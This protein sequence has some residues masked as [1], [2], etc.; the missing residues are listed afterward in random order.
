MAK[1]IVR[2]FES[3][4]E[5]RPFASKGHAEI[6]H[7]GQGAVGRGVFEPG[8]KW[9]ESVK[10]LAGTR[11]CETP[12]LGF[13]AS[14]RMHVRMDDGEE[15]DIGP[16]DVVS[17]APG[18]DAWVVGNEAC[19]ILD[20]AGMEHYAQPAEAGRGAEAEPQQPGMH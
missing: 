18:H 7:L 11:S 15:A 9:S 16:G 4:D 13:V 3:P 10:P 6:V 5:T 2:K 12:H 19:V 8:W 1:L 20:F 17:I 14:G